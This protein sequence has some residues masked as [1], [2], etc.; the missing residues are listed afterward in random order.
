MHASHPIMLAHLP[1]AVT[2]PRSSAP[3]PAR[4]RDP[5]GPPLAHPPLVLGLLVVVLVMAVVPP[6]SRGRDHG[7]GLARGVVGA[8]LCA[9]AGDTDRVTAPQAHFPSRGVQ[10][11][12]T[13][14]PR[15]RCARLL[16][17]VPFPALLVSTGP[18][19]SNREGERAGG[20][21][22][23]RAEGLGWGLASGRREAR[24]GEGAGGTASRDREQ[25]Q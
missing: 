11:Q 19:A 5:P 10:G 13:D 4:P 23:Q 14:T 6:P 16:P 24:L 25:N 3:A 17:Y 7:P 9:G 12:Q 1:P 21:G 20:P 18:Q 8:V 2:G 22:A 15:G